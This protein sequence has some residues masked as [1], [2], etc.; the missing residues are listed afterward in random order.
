[1]L[2]NAR[3]E[4]ERYKKAVV[5]GYVRAS[6]TQFMTALKTAQATIDGGP[7]AVAHRARAR[8]SR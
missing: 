7:R 4:E 5:G 8:A 2:E 3:V 6:S 1:M